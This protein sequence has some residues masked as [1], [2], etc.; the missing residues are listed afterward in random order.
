MAPA[1]SKCHY[2]L[3][4]VI[5]REEERFLKYAFRARYA[6]AETREEIADERGVRWSS[7]D[8]L[9]G[10]LPVTSTPT[11][12]MH[13]AFLGAFNRHLACKDLTQCD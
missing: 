10:W 3:I 1:D 6:N 9:P 2:H 11:E 8:L 13:A 5:Y 12:F 4:E 7:L